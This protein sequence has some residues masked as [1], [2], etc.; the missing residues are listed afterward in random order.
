MHID[1]DL[2]KEAEYHA[3]KLKEKKSQFYKEIL[4]ENT[5]KAQELWKALKLL[6]LLSKKGS[7]SNIMSQKT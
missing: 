5:D 1:K 4:K 3:L 6:G 2:Y 7:V